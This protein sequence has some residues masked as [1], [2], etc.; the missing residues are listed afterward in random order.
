M[1]SCADEMAPSNE[2]S[3]TPEPGPYIHQS[4]WGYPYYEENSDIIAADTILHL[5]ID[6][7]EDW[8]L[9]GGIYHDD[10]YL[11]LDGYEVP[12][13]MGLILE[14]PYGPDG[15]FDLEMSYGGNSL[16][17]EGVV[18]A[19][20]DLLEGTFTVNEDAYIKLMYLMCDP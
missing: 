6:R 12:E 4:S 10:G 2:D 3:P 15:R 1:I 13:G 17:Y 9:E 5:N 16:R 18:N 8:W 14:G 7:Q 11:F 19:E 20:M